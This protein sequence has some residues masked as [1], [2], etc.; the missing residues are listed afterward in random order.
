MATGAINVSSLFKYFLI[1]KS[2]A[3]TR[4]SIKYSNLQLTDKRQL[5]PLLKEGGCWWEILVE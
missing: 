5:P 3:F 2:S 4:L 1:A